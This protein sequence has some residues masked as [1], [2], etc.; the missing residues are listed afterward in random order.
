MVQTRPLSKPASPS[1]N[2]PAQALAIQLPFEWLMRSHP[3]ALH[4]AALS[5][6]GRR[7]SGF[8]LMFGVNDALVLRWEFEASNFTGLAW[9]ICTTDEPEA[10]LHAER[11][12][13]IAQAMNSL[14]PEYHG[15]TEATGWWPWWAFSDST[16]DVPRN[17]TQEPDAWVQLLGRDSDSFAEK[18]VAI[19]T[20]I[21]QQMDLTLFHP[22]PLKA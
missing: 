3:A 7:Y 19:A 2:P 11:F 18:V 12:T 22:L 4:T 13:T 20:R 10:R 14:F 17:W 16:L 15:T 8:R 6:D 21:H 1:T 9:G 5:A